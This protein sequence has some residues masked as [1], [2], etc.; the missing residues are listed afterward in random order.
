MNKKVAFHTLGCKVNYYEIE[1]VWGLF[2]QE[3]YDRVDFKSL[4]DVYVINSCTVTNG[5]DKKSRQ[6][7]RRAIR[8]NP[9]AVV[10]VMGCMAQTQAKEVAAIP[11][12]DIVIG[13][14]GRSEIIGLVNRYEQERLPINTVLDNIF[15]EKKFETLKVN[16][17][18]NRKRAALKIQDGCNKFCSFCIIPWAR[19]R[20]RSEEPEEVL[21]QAKALVEA[22]HIELVLTGIHTAAYGEDLENYT[23]ADLL[24]DLCDIDGLE[25]LRISS[26]EASQITD[27][28][29]KVMRSNHSIIA[30]HIHVPIQSG[31]DE[32]LTAMRRTYTLAEYEEKIAS[33]RTIFPDI[34]ITTDIIVGFPGETE[35]NFLESIETVKR[36]GFAE[37]HVFP[38]SL[39]NGTKA[40]TMPDHVPEITKTMRVSKMI[41]V[42]DQLGKDYADKFLGDVLEVIVEKVEDGYATGHASNYLNIKFSVPDDFDKS[43][44]KVKLQRTGY[45]ENYGEIAR[46]GYKWRKLLA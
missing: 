39:R 33:L 37:L 44:V 23:F 40:A 14:T 31:S 8:Q 41:E 10:C 34:S 25:R 1:A 24:H 38:Y 46:G 7:I 35:E 21:R 28:V 5:G 4:A 2:E 13:T 19:G 11:G 36:I 27:E 20:V 30:D 22:G 16:R 45:P 42:N 6:I 9:E 26:I 17:F 32:I 3:G 12:V 43:I 15:K 18:D 29:I